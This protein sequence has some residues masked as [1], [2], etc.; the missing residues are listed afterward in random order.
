M[1]RFES[2]IET[3]LGNKLDYAGYL[4]LDELLGAQHTRSIPPHHDELLFII[5]HQTAELWM[6][7]LIH[8]L[9]E[10]IAFVKEDSI[11]PA[12]KILA[13]VKQVQRILFEQWAVLETLTPSEYAQFRHVLGPASGLQSHQYRAIEFLLGNKD[14]AMIRVFHH[15]PKVHAFLE[16]VLHKPSVYDELLRYLRRRGFDIP[17]ACFERDWTQPYHAN[18]GLLPAIKQVYEAPRDNWAEYEMFEKLLDV[19]EQQ[20]LWRV[21]HVTI[22]ERIIG[23]K[24]GTGGSSGAAFLR[25]GLDIRLF[26]ELWDVRTEIGA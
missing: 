22:V 6:K 21:R 5:Q 7:L 4:A 24:R 19:E 18:P 10:V 25:K 20:I 9:Q 3:E 2:S 26:P 16:G 13:R 12:F 14:A 17:E 1:D 23:F 15:K 8:E 11:E